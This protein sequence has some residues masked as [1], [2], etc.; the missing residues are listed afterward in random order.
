MADRLDIT[1][2]YFESCNCFAPCSCI[3]LSAPT[4]GDCKVLL[5]WHIDQGKLGSIK[6]DGLNAA[7]FAHAPGHMMQTK[8]KVA[9]YVDER[10]NAAQQEALGKAFSGQAGGPLAALAPLIG[11]VMGVRP[12]AI[13]YRAEGKRRS[14]RI[15]GVGQAEI[16][17]LAGQDGGDVTISNHPF[18][19]VPGQT[20]VVGKSTQTR[21]D[22]H[23]Y[24]VELSGR[25]GLYSPFV[26]RN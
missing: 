9:L 1:G 6:L 17:A 12:A 7:L 3:C 19:P 26:Y 24:Q 25:S 22:D 10:A 13:E 11:E 4:E 21:Y 16:E 14:V 5:A 15:D 20:A 18:T 8:W 23:G 2:S